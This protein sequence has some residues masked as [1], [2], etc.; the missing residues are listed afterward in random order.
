VV[1]VVDNVYDAH[2]ADSPKETWYLPYEQMAG[3][4]AAE[5]FYLMVRDGDA[6]LTIVDDVR[7]AVAQVD[8]VLAPYKPA[9]MDAYFDESIGRERVSASLMLGFGAF[10]L[11]L[12]SLGVYGV[13]ALTVAQRVPEF[14]IRVALGARP[15][16]LVPLAVSRGL[17]LVVGGIGT[18]AFI[19]LV[20]NR[21]IGGM[22]LEGGAIDFPMLGIAATLILC[23][24]V[25]AC[26]LPAL[27]ISRLDPVDALRAE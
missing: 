4:A 22:L 17:A 5:H 14:G 19:A 7:H 18:G 3:T 20:V 24:A 23:A 10:G 21:L 2:D 6:P 9:A 11:L 26:A 27:T 15:T 25:A 12:A 1:G 13:M 16:D 8:P